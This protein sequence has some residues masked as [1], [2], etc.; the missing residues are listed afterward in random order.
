M[1]KC[2]LISIFALLAIGTAVAQ[3]RTWQIAQAGW[4]RIEKGIAIA[5]AM[6]E[7]T[8]GEIIIPRWRKA[9][10]TLTVDFDKKDVVLAQRGKAEKT[11]NLLTEGNTKT[12]RA[13]WSY[14]EYMALDAHNSVCHFWLCKHES[15]AARLLLL[16]PWRY[17]DTV[18]GYD[19]TPA[20]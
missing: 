5:Q 2:L 20:E 12:T 18:Y 17:P 9:S 7:Q 6:P 19:L 16:Y 8:V 13:G 1:K 10:G 3:P 4:G 15:G 14:V 11:Y